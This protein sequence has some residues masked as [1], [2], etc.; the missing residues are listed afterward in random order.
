[1]YICIYKAVGC[2]EL[3]D[4]VR[5]VRSKLPIYTIITITRAFFTIITIITVFRRTLDI[6]HDVTYACLY[7]W[8]ATLDNFRLHCTVLALHVHACGRCA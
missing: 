3:D 8:H 4:Q 6:L 7:S 5:M 1:M 2:A